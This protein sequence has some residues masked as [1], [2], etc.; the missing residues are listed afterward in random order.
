[1]PQYAS[2]NL[3]SAARETLIPLVQS[4][5]GRRDVAEIEALCEAAGL[6]FA[7]INRPWD[8]FED[9]HLLASGGLLP[10]TLADGTTA[11]VPALPMQLGERRLGI[12]H[13]LPSPGQHN[14]DILAPLRAARSAE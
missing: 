7:R 13:D 2:N 8:L 1:M 3:R 10:V 12:R 11:M 6:P 5:L 4:I 14:E 9:P